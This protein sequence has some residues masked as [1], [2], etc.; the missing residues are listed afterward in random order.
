MA[1]DEAADEETVD[2][3]MAADEAT[4]DEGTAADE[5]IVDEGTTADEG[6]V[7]DD[8]MGCGTAVAVA[9]GCSRPACWGG[10]GSTRRPF[11]SPR[12]ARIRPESGAST[13]AFLSEF[14]LIGSE[15]R[16]KQARPDQPARRSGF[17]PKGFLTTT[18]QGR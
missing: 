14:I 16:A 4:I 1:D 3:G 17:R 6:A 18:P 10:S 9:V 2:E 12:P 8:V 7:A 13:S 5:E 15:A 11:D